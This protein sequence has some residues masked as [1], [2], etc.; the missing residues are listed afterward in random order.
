MPKVN[1]FSIVRISPL[2][3]HSTEDGFLD[4]LSAIGQLE[5]HSKQGEH[6]HLKQI[7]KKVNM[8]KTKMDRHIKDVHEGSTLY[9]VALICGI[10]TI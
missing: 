9:V 8:D 6:L 1:V 5:P 3:Y 2:L 10:H 4:R 7:K